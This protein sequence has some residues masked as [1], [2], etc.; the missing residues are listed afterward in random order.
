MSKIRNG[1]VITF[2][3]VLAFFIFHTTSNAE[4]SANP[5]IENRDEPNIR[6]EELEN[7]LKRLEPPEP[8]NI[9]ELPF[10]SEAKKRYP[11]QTISISE[12]M[13]KGTKIHFDIIKNIPDYKRPVYE[14]LW[15]STYGV[16][17]GV[18]FLYDWGSLAV[19]RTSLI[20]NESLQDVT[21]GI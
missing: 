14:K 16:A 7:R 18:I 8:V 17:D 11:S 10:E 5:L 3:I 12:V 1:Y 9:I 21:I 6:V 13:E 4:V 19:V 15:H 2:S 20:L